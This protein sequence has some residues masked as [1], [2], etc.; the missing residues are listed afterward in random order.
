ML[1]TTKDR[2][3]NMFPENKKGVSDPSF[4]SD[5]DMRIKSVSYGVEKYLRRGIDSISRV[6]RFTPET[7]LGTK[8]VRLS[9]FPVSSVTSVVIFGD[10]YTEGSDFIVDNES[11]VISFLNRIFRETPLYEN[12]IVVTYIGG[13]ATDTDNFV[14]LYPDIESEVLTQIQFELT[15]IKTI[16][17]KSQS[18]G[19]SSSQLN[20]YG[21]TNSLIACLDR[22]RKVSWA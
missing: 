6:N 4:I 22:Y 20:D 14:D 19:A 3:F 17:L 10:E 5:L 1:L 16:A 7:G 9:A 12:A 15:R 11:G 2:F 13:M 8:Q 18:N 21:L